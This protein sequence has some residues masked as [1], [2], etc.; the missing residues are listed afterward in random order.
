MRYASVIKRKWGLAV[1]PWLLAFSWVCPNAAGAG[2]DQQTDSASAAVR[3][4]QERRL[5]IQEIS[6][7]TQVPW[8]Y[9]AAL[10]QYER[11]LTPKSRKERLK[12]KLISLDPRPELW[13]GMINP[14]PGDTN[15]ITIALFGGIGRDANGDGKANPEDDMDALYSLASYMKSFGLTEEDFQI[16]LWRY[17]QNERAV[18]RI[19]QFA[20]LYQ[21]YGTIDLS[22]TAFVLPLSSIYS[23]RSTWGDRR[24]FGGL[25]MHE[26][27]DLFASYGVP[28]RSACYGVVE[29][30]GWNR[31]GGWRIG[32]RDIQNR[33]HYYAHLQGFDK[34]IE[35]G[36]TVVP[37]QV[38]GWVGSS[39]YGKPGTSGKF[40][41]H[42][43]YGIYK[44][45][46][47]YEWAF[48]PY[49]LLK[50]WENEERRRK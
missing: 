12:N 25:R 14:D 24:G 26:G 23:Y 42:L 48:D 36:S 21:T 45:T 5:L 9:L 44:D 15:P 3:T 6:E 46:G 17:Y 19:R 2:T 7:L 30:K 38:V 31:F 37:G 47:H 27:T 35:V 29:T 28:V 49:P 32:I 4:L 11:T 13:A 43:H 8:T 40:P 16:S 20:K 22:K 41:P 18:T 50:R 34:N 39:G 33:Y 10:D 1:L